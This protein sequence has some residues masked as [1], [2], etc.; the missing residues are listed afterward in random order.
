MVL[1][2]KKWH[3][4]AT[5]KF[6]RCC[7][8]EPKFLLLIW[9]MEGRGWVVSYA[10]WGLLLALQVLDPGRNN[11]GLVLRAIVS[12]LAAVQIAIDPDKPSFGAFLDHFLGQFPESDHGM[13]IRRTLFRQA[14]SYS[15]I[16]HAQKQN[17]ARE[18]SLTS[19]SEVKIHNRCAPGC[20]FAGAD[21]AHG[22]FAPLDGDFD[23]AMRCSFLEPR[24]SV[25]VGVHTG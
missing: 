13:P 14:C 19:L 15:A 6:K 3:C 18:S 23:F 17:R 8:A 12:A 2:K 4:G 20:V 11:F 22:A 21:A 7:R 24:L 16:R 1:T 10:P 9:K 25:S 5:T